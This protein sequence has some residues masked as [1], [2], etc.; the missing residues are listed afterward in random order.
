MGYHTARLE[1]LVGYVSRTWIRNVLWPPTAWSAYQLPVR[2]NND[3]EG[4]H[5]RLKKKAR[6][7]LLNVYLLVRLLQKEAECVDLQVKLVSDGKLTRKQKK[8]MSKF[9]PSS[10]TLGTNTN[11][12]KTA[13]QLLKACAYVY[14]PV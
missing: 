2:T 5:N 6:K 14:E 12:V 11:G 7:R 13:G 4:W 9:M 10:T 3:V 8:S 1:K